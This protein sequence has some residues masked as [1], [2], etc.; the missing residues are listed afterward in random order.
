MLSP[1]FVPSPPASLI[2]HTFRTH[3]AERELT[4]YRKTL[5]YYAQVKRSAAELLILSDELAPP[6]MLLAA[7]CKAA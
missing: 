7:Q 4:Q 3:A 5:T 6:I 1:I 2:P